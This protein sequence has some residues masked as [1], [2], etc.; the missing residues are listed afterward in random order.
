MV[1]IHVL[2]LEP[3]EWDQSGDELELVPRGPAPRPQQWR[4]LP[5]RATRI[6]RRRLAVLMLLAGLIVGSV[7][8]VNAMAHGAGAPPVIPETDPGPITGDIY[9]VQPGDSLWSIAQ[10][11]APGEDPRPIVDELRKRNGGIDLDVGDRVSV[12]IS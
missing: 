3:E 1:A 6:R 9:V 4:R 12:D 2:P 5:T 11:L 7:A 10:R 8:L